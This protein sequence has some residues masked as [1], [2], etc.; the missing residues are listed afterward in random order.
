[1]QEQID[2]SLNPSSSALEALFYEQE[3][4]EKE[5][6]LARELALL[7]VGPKMTLAKVAALIL[8]VVLMIGAGQIFVKQQEEFR[9]VAFRQEEIAQEL[10]EVVQESIDIEA[11]YRDIESAEQLEKLARE[12]LGF[13]RAGDMV[14]Q[15]E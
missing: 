6:N 15:E 7:E 3:Q 10:A 5:K 11:Q 13:V 2:E 1:M 8:T 9:R 12:N 4:K 14:F